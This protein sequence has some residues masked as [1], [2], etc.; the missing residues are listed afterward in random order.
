V[1][2]LAVTNV[3]SSKQ[4]VFL[5]CWLSISFLQFFEDQKKCQD[6]YARWQDFDL[7]FK[8]VE[9]SKIIFHVKN[10][11]DDERKYLGSILLLLLLLLLLTANRLDAQLEALPKRK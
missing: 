6:N 8:K 9:N 5:S 11:D 3:P 1:S 10:N 2:T 4:F 7:F